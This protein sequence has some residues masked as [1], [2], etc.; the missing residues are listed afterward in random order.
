MGDLI[1][2]DVSMCA[3]QIANFLSMSVLMLEI[4]RVPR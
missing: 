1:L 3:P 2:V 4:G